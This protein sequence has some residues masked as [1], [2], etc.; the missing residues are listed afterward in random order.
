MQKNKNK[1]INKCVIRRFIKRLKNYLYKLL[2]KERS[3]IINH[4][5]LDFANR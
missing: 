5:L 2:S 3:T 1:K 4:F